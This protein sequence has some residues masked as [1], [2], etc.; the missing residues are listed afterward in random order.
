MADELPPT[1]EQ[2]AHEAAEVRLLMSKDLVQ[3]AFRETELAIVNQWTNAQDTAA[4][5][6]CW[7]KLQAF[8]ELQTKLRALSNRTHLQIA[9]E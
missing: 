1:A 7:H 3:R 9:K 4:R 5:E 2:L 6:A 8:R